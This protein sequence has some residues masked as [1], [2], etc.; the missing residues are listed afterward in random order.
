MKDTDSLAKAALVE[1]E[2]NKTFVNIPVLNLTGFDKEFHMMVL[3]GGSRMI[4]KFFGLCNWMGIILI[5]EIGII[6]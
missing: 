4:A 5:L 3:G 1:M 6:K 2:Q